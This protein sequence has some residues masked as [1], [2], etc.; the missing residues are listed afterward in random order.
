MQYKLRKPR[1]PG[2]TGVLIPTEA[3]LRRCV[4][5][6]RFDDSRHPAPEILLPLR[7]SV[8]FDCRRPPGPLRFDR[9]PTVGRCLFLVTGSDPQE[10]AGD[11]VFLDHTERYEASSEFYSY[12]APPDGRRNRDLQCGKHQRVRGAKLLFPPAEPR[13]PLYFGGSSDVA[14]ICRRRAGRSLSHRE[15]PPEQVAEKIAQCV[16]SRSSRS[17]RS[18][19]WYSSACHC[20]GNQ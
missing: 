2:F 12:L 17:Y 16:K 15:S 20:P 13:P 8:T 7:P 9:C 14:Q 4:A 3:L 19:S 10:L 11:G 18:V 5:G 6:C 1:L